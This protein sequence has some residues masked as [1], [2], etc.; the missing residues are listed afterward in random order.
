MKTSNYK[1]HAKDPRAVSIAGRAPDNYKGR[2]YKKLAPKI[3][4]FKKYKK[5]GN[6]KYYIKHYYKEVLDA[7]NPYEVYQDLGEDAILLCWEP[8]GKFCHRHIVAEWLRD[9]IGIIIEEAS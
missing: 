2:Q 3:W 1:K 7:L 6:E 4:F 9:K 8:P 5:D